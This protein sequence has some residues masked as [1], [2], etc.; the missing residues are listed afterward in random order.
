MGPVH[1]FGPICAA[2]FVPATASL[3]ILLQSQKGWSQPK[4]PRDLEQLIPSGGEPGGR[5]SAGFTCYAVDWA[6]QAT[7]GFPR[8]AGLGARD[9][10]KQ[11]DDYALGRR[12]ANDIMSPIVR[13]LSEQDR[14][15]VSL[16]YEALSPKSATLVRN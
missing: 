1:R 3:G 14:Q 6:G 9:L 15:A 13:E 10:A 7:S 2:M 12:R 5:G 8:I 4:R 11:L 16:Y